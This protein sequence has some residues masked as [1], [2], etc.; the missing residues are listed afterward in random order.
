MVRPRQTV[1]LVTDLHFPKA[2]VDVSRPAA[3]QPAR[4]TGPGNEYARTTPV[5]VNV[6]GYD[7]RLQRFRGG[8]RPGLVKQVPTPLV[9]GW[10][11][12]HLNTLVTA[13]DAAL[14]TTQ[15]G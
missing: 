6:R 4:P 2:G 12:Q 15:S 7:A 10:V 13:E 11:V 3:R 9:A 5:G 1:E 14:A 8:A